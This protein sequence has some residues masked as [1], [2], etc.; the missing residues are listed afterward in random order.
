VLRF[1]AAELLLLLRFLVLV[2]ATRWRKS[3][4]VKRVSSGL[5]RE[6]DAGFPGGAELDRQFEHSG[7][8]TTS[9]AA[10]ARLR[11]AC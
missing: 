8:Q 4:T 11:R 5:G 9:S 7:D 10:V 6:A 2:P 3:A 1:A